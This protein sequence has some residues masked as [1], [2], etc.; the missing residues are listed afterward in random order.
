MAIKP[1]GVFLSNLRN[2]AELS[3]EELAVLANSSKST[4]S[5]LENDRVPRPFKGPIRKLIL[6]LCE[7]LCNSPKEVEL[8]LTLSDIPRSLLTEVEEIQAGFG[9]LIPMAI[10]E[11]QGNLERLECLY[12]QRLEDLEKRKKSVQR[13]PANLELRLHHYESKVGDIRQRLEK[14]QSLQAQQSPG[15]TKVTLHASVELP[16]EDSILMLNFTYALTS[17]Q[18]AR[19][20]KLAGI[21]I[22]NIINIPAQINETEYLA[23]QISA[24][25]NAIGL[26]PEEWRQRTIFINPPGYAPASI[27][28]LAELHGRMGHF[29]SFIRMRPKQGSGTGYEVAEIINLQTLRDLARISNLPSTNHKDS[30][31]KVS[32]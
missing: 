26:S 6:T 12:E 31:I 3:L 2:N 22:G 5:R 1:F 18:L 25:V 8:F 20:E 7:L 30:I 28:L 21:P 15:I 13:F 29:P 4:L 17:H 16:E 9:P 32:N 14:L 23:P 11:E 24:V 10:L 27:V 19:I